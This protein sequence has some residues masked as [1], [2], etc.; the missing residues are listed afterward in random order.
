MRQVLGHLGSVSTG[1]V[2]MRQVLGAF[3][4]REYGGKVR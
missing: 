3:G 2:K 4:K 1:Q